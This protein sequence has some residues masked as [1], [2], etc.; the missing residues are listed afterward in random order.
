MLPAPLPV[1]LPVLNPYETES[2]EN[3]EKSNERPLSLSV[4]SVATGPL[5]TGRE[6]KGV[7]FICLS[8]PIPSPLLPQCKRIIQGAETIDHVVWPCP[9]GPEAQEFPEKPGRGGPR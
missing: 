3:E 6:R 7:C 1:I 8:D 5:S 2:A 4:L 9:Q